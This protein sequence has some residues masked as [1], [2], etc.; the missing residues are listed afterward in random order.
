[1]RIFISMSSTLSLLIAGKVTIEELTDPE[2]AFAFACTRSYVLADP[3]RA[4]WEVTW[5][6]PGDWSGDDW[7][8]AVADL[9]ADRRAAW[10]QF[11][12]AV[13]TA[14]DSHRVW[15]GLGRTD[16]NQ[17]NPFIDSGFESINSF[18][19]AEVLRKQGHTVIHG[20]DNSASA[21]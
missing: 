16:G 7:K 3:D 13:V 5:G 17:E 6:L 10:E 20:A 14:H 12:A 18:T 1:M 21:R 15:W 11:R 9:P 2:T 4:P 8:V 19:A